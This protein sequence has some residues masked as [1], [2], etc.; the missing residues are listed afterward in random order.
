MDKV[1]SKVFKSHQDELE[2]NFEGLKIQI[3]T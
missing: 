3:E 2:K 1:G